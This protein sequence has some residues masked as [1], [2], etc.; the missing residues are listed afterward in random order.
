MQWHSLCLLEASV[1]VLIYYCLNNFIRVRAFA[2]TFYEHRR[3]NA[4]IEQRTDLILLALSR[5]L[6]ARN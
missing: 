3:G 6:L 2:G 4:L 1:W 5:Q